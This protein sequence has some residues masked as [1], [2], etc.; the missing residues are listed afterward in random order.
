MNVGDCMDE[1]K[2]SIEDIDSYFKFFDDGMSYDE[3]KKFVDE[4]IGSKN[5]YLKRLIVMVR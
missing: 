1:Y 2:D 3:R 5:E 4:V